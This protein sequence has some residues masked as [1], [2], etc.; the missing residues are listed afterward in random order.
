MACWCLSYCKTTL[1]C[2]CSVTSWLD[3]GWG[4]V[5]YGP[6]FT[7][8]YLPKRSEGKQCIQYAGRTRYSR[9]ILFKAY[10]RRG[11]SLNLKWHQLI[12][13]AVKGE[14]AEEINDNSR[15]LCA[16]FGTSFKAESNIAT[17]KVQIFSRLRPRLPHFNVLGVCLRR[18]IV[19]S[20]YALPNRQSSDS[21]RCLPTNW[22]LKGIPSLFRP[23][24]TERVGTPLKS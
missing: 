6:A 18:N 14:L 10:F 2:Q 1:F 8:H 20:S 13:S 11:K 5:P 19:A 17:V 22:R 7:M 16:I 23:H 12:R 15:R 3:K 4:K 24:G 21:D 9:P